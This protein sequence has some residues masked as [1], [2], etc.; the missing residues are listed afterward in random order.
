MIKIERSIFRKTFA[1]AAS[2]VMTVCANAQQLNVLGGVIKNISD[3][4]LSMICQV[5]YWADHPKLFSTSISY[6]NEGHFNAHH[7]DGM[8]C[9]IWLRLDAPKLVLAAGSGPYAFCDTTDGGDNIRFRNK[10]GI[11]LVSSM[12]MKWRTA[13]RLKPV[14]RCNWIVTGEIDTFSFLTGLEL[15]ING[16]DSGI[17]SRLV[18]PEPTVYRNEI[19]LFTGK[20]IV[21]SYSSRD[22]MPWSL[23]YR[24]QICRHVE[25]TVAGL[26]EGHDRVLDRAGIAAQLWLVDSLDDLPLRLGLG[27]GAYFA[28]DRSGDGHEMLAGIVSITGSWQFHPRHNLRVTWHRVV[29]DYNRDTDIILVGVGRCF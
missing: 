22:L 18:A 15:N 5:E 9:Q 23:E 12:T 20:T 11:G 19:T 28:G 3:D 1:V 21:N 14:F 10:H 25:G 8:A 24:R 7:R 6:L 2:A 13:S 17:P 29:S 16:M 4:E 26:Y 27:T